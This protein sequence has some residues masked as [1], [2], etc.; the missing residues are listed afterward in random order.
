M[1]V[2]LRS[3]DG[4]RFV[5]PPTA[6]SS[7]G[8]ARD[9]CEHAAAAAGEH[10]IQAPFPSAALA[11]VTSL[12]TD[13]AAAATA[14]LAD[15]NLFHALRAATYLDAPM[16][17][18]RG[19]ASRVAAKLSRGAQRALDTESVFLSAEEER[20]AASERDLGA[21]AGIAADG[22]WATSS[23]TRWPRSCGLTARTQACCSLSRAV[24]GRC[25]SWL[26]APLRATEAAS[27]GATHPAGCAR[28][29]SCST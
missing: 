21:A 10:T 13:P 9:V 19:L 25:G 16:P 14:P 24:A 29:A 5:L 12:V 8:L 28:A 7:L 20:G 26:A 1:A 15:A 17:L 6:A 4:G 3:S 27:A 2:C 23:P 22:H 11:Y 18:L